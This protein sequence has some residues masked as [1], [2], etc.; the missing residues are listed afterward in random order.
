V[1]VV[2]VVM[3]TGSVPSVGSVVV[4]C[5]VVVCSVVVVGDSVVV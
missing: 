1:V 2:A 5:V 4:G 3:S